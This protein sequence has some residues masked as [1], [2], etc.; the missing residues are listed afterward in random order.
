[1]DNKAK[2]NEYILNDYCKG[3]AEV[4]DNCLDYR[5]IAHDPNASLLANEIYAGFVQAKIQGYLDN[6]ATRHDV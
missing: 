2:I 4:I 3:Y 1:M 6:K 5:N